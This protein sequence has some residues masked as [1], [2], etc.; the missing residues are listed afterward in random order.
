VGHQS[1]QPP[2]WPPPPT[3]RSPNPCAIG[4]AHCQC[5]PPTLDAC[6]A[7]KCMAVTRGAIVGRWHSQF[8]RLA[9]FC[10]PQ[11]STPNLDEKI[12]LRSPYVA[13]LNVLQV[14]GWISVCMCVCVG[15]S[16]RVRTTNASRVGGKALPA[17][18]MPPRP[19]CT[20][21]GPPWAVL[22]Q[23]VLQRLVSIAV[24]SI[25]FLSTSAGAQPPGPAQVPRRSGD[26]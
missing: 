14:R 22:P 2:V 9:L 1:A 6:R 10:T 17:Q 8:P 20:S 3:G 15:I 24:V 16:V 25:W 11:V 19:S 23:P 7:T 26:R 12:R 5:R 18:G 21:P 4:P 13:P